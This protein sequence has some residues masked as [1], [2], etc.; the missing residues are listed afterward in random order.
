MYTDKQNKKWQ[1]YRAVHC[2]RLAIDIPRGEK[3]RY[4]A[5]AERIGKPLR[6]LIMDLID[7]D[8]KRVDAETGKPLDVEPEGGTK[9][10]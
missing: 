1:E 2:D 8:I 3:S 6:R 5:H 4:K 7:E 9:S 10:D